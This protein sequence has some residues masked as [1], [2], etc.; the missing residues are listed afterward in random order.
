MPILIDDLLLK[1]TNLLK[2]TIGLHTFIKVVDNKITITHGFKSNEYLEIKHYIE[3]N[4]LDLKEF[5]DIAYSYGSSL[6]CNYNKL[7]VI[8]C[9][10]DYIWKGIT[11]RDHI[12]RDGYDWQSLAFDE[13]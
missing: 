11:I 12:T 1:T 2:K 6:K 10:K 13:Y 3:T 9:T 4:G 8:S 5:N 7:D